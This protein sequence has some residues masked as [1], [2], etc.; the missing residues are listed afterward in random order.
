MNNEHK[1][2]AGIQ[3]LTNSL[4]PIEQRTAPGIFDGAI[5]KWGPIP[6]DLVYAIDQ[7]NWR[8]HIDDPLTVGLA[9]MLTGAL[10][11]EWIETG[12][13]LISLEATT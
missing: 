7:L 8:Q 9:F 2:T 1:C 12:N 5:E 13:I 4:L 10:T 3:V 11:M 6:E